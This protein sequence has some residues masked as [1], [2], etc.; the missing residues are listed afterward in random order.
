MTTATTLTTGSS[1][2]SPGL[3]KPVPIPSWQVASLNTL[4]AQGKLSGIPAAF[5]EVIDSAESSGGG[6]GIN[7]ANYGGFFGLA[8][9]GHYPAGTSTRALLSTPGPGSF[10]TQ[11]QIAASEFASLLP[12]AG[13]TPLRAESAYQQGPNA[14]FNPSGEGVRF[15]EEYLGLSPGSSKVTGSPAGSSSATGGSS[16][17]SSSSLLTYIPGVGTPI[18]SGLQALFR[19]FE[20]LAIMLLGMV[21]IVIGLVVIAKGAGK[22]QGTGGAAGGEGKK[23][24]EGEGAGKKGA[25]S[26]EAEAAEAAAVA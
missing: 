4:A 26:E 5:L 11:A 23:K 6:G 18:A 15:F 13:G 17:P 10:A 14:P 24:E 2:S 20:N 3:V 7:S 12:G 16:S 1:A 22:G 9:T 25:E 19:P 8:G 21:L